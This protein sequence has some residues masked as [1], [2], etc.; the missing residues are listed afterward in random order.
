MFISGFGNRSCV[1]REKFLLGISLLTYS[2]NQHLQQSTARVGLSAGLYDYPIRRVSSDSDRIIKW[3]VMLGF[4]IIRKRLS[5][6]V[7]FA[8]LHID[9]SPSPG[10]IKLSLRDKVDLLVSYWLFELDGLNTQFANLAVF[11]KSI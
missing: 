4:Q 11:T 1:F 3:R 5:E 9:F 10:V 8:F 7:F 2:Q 6:D